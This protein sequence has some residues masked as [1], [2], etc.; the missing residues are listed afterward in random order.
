M[1]QNKRSFPMH[2]LDI[3]FFG[4]P[5]K[6]SINIISLWNLFAA[7]RIAASVQEKARTHPL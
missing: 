2:F 3:I 6:A 5:K 4:G 7:N 1:N